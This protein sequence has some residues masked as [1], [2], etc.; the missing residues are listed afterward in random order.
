MR[1]REDRTAAPVPRHI[2][3]TRSA[4]GAVTGA[5]GGRLTFVTASQESM[6][7]AARSSRSGRRS[8]TD[9]GD[10]VAG[11]RESAGEPLTSYM[12]A[13]PRAADKHGRLK[14][15]ARQ[16]ATHKGFPFG[17]RSM[18]AKTRS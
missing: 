10:P 14:S 1:A 16:F 3:V 18:Q 8:V 5:L 13:W 11:S 12:E 17:R 6:R 15:S 7:K 9:G 4:N 2:S